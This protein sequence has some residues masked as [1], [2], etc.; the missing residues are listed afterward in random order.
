[1]PN[2]SSL[3]ALQLDCCSCNICFTRN[4]LAGRVIS[5]SW[6]LSSLI[7]SLLSAARACPLGEVSLTARQISSNEADLGTAFTEPRKMQ[8]AC[9]TIPKGDC[10]VEHNFP[11]F[12]F[13]LSQD[14]EARSSQTCAR[15]I[16]NNGANVVCYSFLD[17][18]TPGIRRSMQAIY[19]KDNLYLQCYY[20]AMVYVLFFLQRVY[21]GA[22]PFCCF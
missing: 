3:C 5:R 12:L 9:Q 13:W 17:C 14:A 21:F 6:N 20:F 8:R 4:G 15:D 18:D 1:M 10:T 22:F 19:K 2:L 11:L 7:L 16:A